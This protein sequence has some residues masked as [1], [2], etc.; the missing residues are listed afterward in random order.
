MITEGATVLAI[1]NLDS[2]SGAQIQKQADAEGVQTIDYDRLTL[3]GPAQA[4]V[5]FDNVH[6]GR[7][8]GEGR[9]E[10]RRGGEEGSSRWSPDHSSRRR[11]TRYWRDWSSDVCSSDLHRGRHRPGD[12]QPRLGLRGADPEAGGRR[13]GADHRLRPAHAR[14]YGSGLRVLRQRPGRSTPGRGQIG[15]AAWRG[16]GQLSVVAGSFKQKTAYEILA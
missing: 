5:S 12:R 6:V 2:A 13:R 4:Y 7:L 8:Q 16:R 1:V 11:H 9:S 15:R 10:E 3:G 14:R